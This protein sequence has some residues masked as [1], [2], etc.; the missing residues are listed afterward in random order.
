MKEAF[1]FFGIPMTIGIIVSIIII[2][3]KIMIFFSIISL[4]KNVDEI[5]EKIEHL[6]EVQKESNYTIIKE[7]TKLNDTQLKIAQML[8]EIK[9]N[10]KG[11]ADIERNSNENR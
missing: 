4:E 3:A 6:I 1:A 9:T 8:F 5:D 10:G 11:S 2:V 7:L